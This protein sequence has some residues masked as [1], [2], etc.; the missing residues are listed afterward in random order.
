MTHLDRAV[1]LYRDDT[2]L[3]KLEVEYTLTEDK[4]EKQALK[5]AILNLREKQG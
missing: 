5:I 1:S 2:K 3:K 4:Q